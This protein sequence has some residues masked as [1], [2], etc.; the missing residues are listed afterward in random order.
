MSYNTRNPKAP[1]VPKPGVSSLPSRDDH[2]HPLQTVPAPATAAPADVAGTAA[3]GTSALYARSDHVHKGPVTS[4]SAF[5]ELLSGQ[6]TLSSNST[7]YTIN[8]RTLHAQLSAS[9]APKMMDFIMRYTSGGVNYVYRFP[10]S[11]A[12]TPL[13]ENE[14][15]T[16][17]CFTYRERTDNMMH[18]EL[19]VS[20][21]GYRIK[22]QNIDARGNPRVNF[23]LW[24]TR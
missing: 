3:V 1:G 15:R 7:D 20:T 18:I 10:C 4:N 23:K 24:G 21:I 11:G 14:N 9:N 22:A 5:V 2:V 6:W 8:T 13:G 12:D 17:F 16:F 19:A